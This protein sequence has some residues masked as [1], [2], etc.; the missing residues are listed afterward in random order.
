M[1]GRDSKGRLSGETT[2]GRDS[3][4]RIAAAEDRI[5]PTT[6]RLWSENAAS[7]PRRAGVVGASP[8]FRTPAPAAKMVL[9]PKRMPSSPRRRP[10]SPEPTPAL[11]PSKMTARPMAVTLLLGLLPI[12]CDVPCQFEQH[13]AKAF[14]VQTCAGG[15]QMEAFPGR[16][17]Q[18]GIR[19][20]GWMEPK[21][22]Y[23]SEER[24]A[25]LGDKAAASRSVSCAEDAGE[26]T[27]D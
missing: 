23:Q 3:K 27:E 22:R 14:R 12:V 20:K 6:A 26:E 2:V 10:S 21:G 1:R 19:K 9:A 7:T 8:P 11:T 4:E 5:I 13:A 16:P 15:I 24:D 17:R 25:E 18:G